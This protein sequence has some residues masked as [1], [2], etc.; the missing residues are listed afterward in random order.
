VSAVRYA[1]VTYRYANSTKPSVDG[2]D[3]RIEPG[4]RVALVG[5][6]G[7]GKT[8]L[9]L[10]ATGLIS[11]TRGHV[12]VAGITV[13]RGT[14]REVR[15][16]LSLVFADPDDQLFCASAIDEV[17][18]T[19]LH[20]GATPAEARDRAMAALKA[21]GLDDRAEREP[22]TL[23]LGEKKRLALATTIA[24]GSDVWLLDEPTSGL[25]PRARKQ[26]I[27]HLAT[28]PHTMVFATHDLDAALTLG[29]RVVLLDGGR[30]A[31]DGPAEIL[32]GDE[33][34]LRAHGLELPLSKGG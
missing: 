29:A 34:L 5:A 32:L 1:A 18:F 4:E 13:S 21:V 16:R 17:M 7:A 23:S 10:L 9:L 6:N 19:P 20:S 26:F 2:V 22:L 25:D 28:H 12:E 31:G 11:P 24:S 30:V 3:L 14:L 27:A 33:A 15:R 8:T